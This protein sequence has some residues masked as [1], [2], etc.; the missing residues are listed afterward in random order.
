MIDVYCVHLHS[1]LYLV[2]LALILQETLEY[3]TFPA[4][5]RDKI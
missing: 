5:A 1:K 3:K 4:Q 2:S